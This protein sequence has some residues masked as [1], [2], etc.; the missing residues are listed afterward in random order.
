MGNKSCCY[1]TTLRSGY[2]CNTSNLRKR[3]FSKQSQESYQINK[4]AGLKSRLF[5]LMLAFICRTAMFSCFTRTYIIGVSIVIT[6][7]YIY[8]I[9]FV[10]VTCINHILISLRRTVQR[11]SGINKRCTAKL[12]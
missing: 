2:D 3:K 6:M 12:I 9:S 10:I 1:R 11:R 7:I 5:Y 8:S 4:K